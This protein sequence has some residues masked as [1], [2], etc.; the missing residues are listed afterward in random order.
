[1]R[2]LPG[3]VHARVRAPGDDERDPPARD[4]GQSVLERPLHG[5]KAGLTRPAAEMRAVVGDVETQSHAQ[6][7][8][9]SR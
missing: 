4:A 7:P 8:S 9:P 3:G 6:P 2:D 5:A 1:M